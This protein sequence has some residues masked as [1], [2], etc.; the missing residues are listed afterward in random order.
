VYL[1][2][3]VRSCQFQSGCNPNNIV[4]TT[5]L[6]ANTVKHPLHL[7]SR[8]S[9]QSV[10][11]GLTTFGNVDY[12]NNK[13]GFWDW[14]I[15]SKLKD[16]MACW[17]NPYDWPLTEAYFDIFL[18]VSMNEFV[19]D[20]WAPNVLVWGYLAARAPTADAAVRGRVTAAKATDIAKQAI[21]EHNVGYYKAG[22]I[23]VKREKGRICVTFPTRPLGPNVRGAD[24]AAK[25][26]VDAE[27][28]K[29]L[30]IWGGR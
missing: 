26:Y 17:P 15:T 1:A 5:G 9:G 6:G 24:Y 13:G 28:G 21:A 18:F 3:L 19:V 8:S 23:T 11:V 2:A 22:K 14:P 20:T 4:Y 16:P 27:S 29:V 25:V 12:W 7:D 10:P 30:E